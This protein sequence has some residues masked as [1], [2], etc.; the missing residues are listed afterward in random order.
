MTLWDYLH[1]HPWLAILHASLLILIIMIS[2]HAAIGVIGIWFGTAKKL[3]ELEDALVWMKKED[4][5][6]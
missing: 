2:M 4:Y 5:D 1:L 3:R 6:V